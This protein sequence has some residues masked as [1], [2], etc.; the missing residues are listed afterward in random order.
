MLAA[1]PRGLLALRTGAVSGLVVI[2]IDPRHGGRLD[3]D[4]MTRTACVASGGADHGWHLLYT[5]PGGYVPSRE[6]PGHPGVD[7]KGDGGYVVLPPSIH[8]ATGRP[9][10]WARDR[11]IHEMHPSPDHVGPGPRGGH[12][13]HTTPPSPRPPCDRCPN[14]TSRRASR[15]R[16]HLISRRPAGRTPGRRG[17]SPRRTTPTHPL[18]RRP[19]RGPHDR[20]R[21]HHRT[22]RLDALTTAGHNAGQT[23][24]QTRNAIIGAFTAEGIPTPERMVN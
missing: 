17:P 9:Y 2:D 8:P 1:H 12:P 5:H 22:A 13:A 24:A 18:R 20:S 21:S 10:R 14:R 23:P 11:E 4:L 15:G 7:V 6:L 19:R 16:V 3:P